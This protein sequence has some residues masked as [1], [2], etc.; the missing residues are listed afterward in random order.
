MAH[1]DNG[2]TDL[3]RILAQTVRTPES[4]L[5]TGDGKGYGRLNGGGVAVIRAPPDVTAYNIGADAESRGAPG[6]ILHL[7][8][9]LKL[10]ISA[11]RKY[12][13]NSCKD[14]GSDKGR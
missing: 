11:S 1:V 3:L 5:E 8:L 2:R 9:I 12:Q 10:G 4:C 14:K 6:L 13:Y 7:V